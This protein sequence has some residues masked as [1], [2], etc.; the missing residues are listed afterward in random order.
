MTKTQE[1]IAAALKLNRGGL[2]LDKLD[3]YRRSIVDVQVCLELAEQRLRSALSFIKDAIAGIR[4]IPEEAIALL[5]EGTRKFL[6][7]CVP[8]FDEAAKDI[9][10]A[11][12]DLQEALY[13]EVVPDDIARGSEI[14]ECPN[15]LVMDSIDAN[16]GGWDNGSVP[17]GTN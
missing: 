12:H 6:E 16:G 13:I 14:G 17:S 15:Q 1:T 7:S 3:R 2:D 9:A 8:F 4:P 10:M 5:P 11:C